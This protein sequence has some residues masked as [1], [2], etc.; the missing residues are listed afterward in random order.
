[1][2]AQKVTTTTSPKGVEKETTTTN[3]LGRS[4]FWT[5]KLR[6][7]SERA[8]DPSRTE[9]QKCESEVLQVLHRGPGGVF[10]RNGGRV[11]SRSSCSVLLSSLGFCSSRSSSSFARSV[12]PCLL[13]SSFPRPGW[14]GPVSLGRVRQ[15]VRVCNVSL[16][17]LCLLRYAEDEH[18]GRRLAA[19]RASS[20][21][22]DSGCGGGGG[23][24]GRVLLTRQG[25]LGAYLEEMTV[26]KVCQRFVWCALLVSTTRN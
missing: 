4:L 7:P 8:R 16:L 21:Q 12:R 15:R 13:P 19:R 23:E 6:L 26:G 20:L 10:S 22:G 18:R 24:F 3:E 14:S 25:R 17:L 9:M 11:C 5:S 1:M 2:G